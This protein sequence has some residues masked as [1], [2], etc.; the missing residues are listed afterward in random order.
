MSVSQLCDQGHNVLFHSKGCKVMDA[1]TR[2]IVVKE[3]R[4]SW[5]VYVLEEGKEIFCS[6]KT[7]ESWTWHKLIGHVSFNHPLKIWRK[8][9]VR[10]MPKISKPNNVV[11]KSS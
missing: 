5:N 2:N 11:Y 1:N 4:T 7:D 9:I 6:G 8:D 3:V 10:D